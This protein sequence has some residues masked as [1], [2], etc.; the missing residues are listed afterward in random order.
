MDFSKSFEPVLLE[1]VISH[2]VCKAF[3]WDV[4]A[5]KKM[6]KSRELDGEIDSKGIATTTTDAIMRK[7]F[8]LRLNLCIKNISL[9]RAIS[10]APCTDYKQMAFRYLCQ[11][12]MGLPPDELQKQLKNGQQLADTYRKTH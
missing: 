4:K 3:G 5:L 10:G 11:E 1:D 7:A 9:E 12:I 6:I 2:P 8:L